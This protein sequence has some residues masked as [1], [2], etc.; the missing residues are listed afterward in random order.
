ME[1]M[2]TGQVIHEI[3]SIPFKSP[4]EVI[5]QEES[6]PFND[7]PAGWDSSVR[8]WRREVRVRNDGDRAIQVGSHFHFYEANP[9]FKVRETEDP[10]CPGR[11]GYQPRGLV[12]LDEDGEEKR[13]L[14]LGYRLDIPAGTAR[15]FEPGYSCDV[16]LVALSGEGT[17]WGLSTEGTLREYSWEREPKPEPEPEPAAE[18]KPVAEPEPAAEAKP[19]AEPEPAAEA[20]PVAESELE[21][22]AK[23]LENMIKNRVFSQP[24]DVIAELV[25]EFCI[26]LL[27]QQGVGK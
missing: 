20:K 11:V 19:V 4:G 10:Q 25:S 18:A 23:L 17:V 22:Y 15:R 8:P 7:E 24:N 3:E 12:I 6:I 27:G 5:H 14:A 26:S 16:R 1:P 21:A 9:G 2:E 13:D